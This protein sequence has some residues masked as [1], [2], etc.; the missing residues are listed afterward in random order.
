MKTNKDLEESIW[1]LFTKHYSLC[2]DGDMDKHYM[3]CSQGSFTRRE[4]LHEFEIR[5]DV[6]KEHIHDLFLLAEDM[7]KRQVARTIENLA[8]LKKEDNKTS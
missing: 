1:E 2:K 3:T 6:A 8:K 5:S 4:F 7:C